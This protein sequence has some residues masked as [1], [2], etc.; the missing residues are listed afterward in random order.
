EIGG[1]KLES[2]FHFSSG[3]PIDE[4]LWLNPF[5]TDKNGDVTWQATNK[6][7][8]SSISS[9][10]IERGVV[11]LGA[12]Q[13]CIFD[14]SQID[15][16]KNFSGGMSLAISQLSNHTLMKVEVQVREWGAHAFTHFRPGLNS[17]R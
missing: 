12:R 5:I 13:S 11:K 17:A 14:P 16:P 3:A 8:P 9:K 4:S 7:L 2:R 15:L 10:Q 6:I 1:V